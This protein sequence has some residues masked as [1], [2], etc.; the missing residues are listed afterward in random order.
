M[1]TS[2]TSRSHWQHENSA[3]KPPPPNKYFLPSDT[4]KITA[5]YIFGTQL[6]NENTKQLRCC[7]FY[8]I[9]TNLIR[10]YVNIWLTVYWSLRLSILPTCQTVCLS[11]F[12]AT[13]D[14]TGVLELRFSAASSLIQLVLS[15]ALPSSTRYPYS[16]AAHKLWSRNR[17][18]VGNEKQEKRKQK[19]AEFF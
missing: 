6:E 11:C 18:K 1:A 8:L 10:S 9:I 15:A 14:C 17:S 12:H 19:P 3:F 16:A 5:F 2:K 7:W 4:I 13:T